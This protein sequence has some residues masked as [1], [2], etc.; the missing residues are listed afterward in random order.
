MMTKK[1]R[2]FKEP[3]LVLLVS[4]LLLILGNSC[5]QTPDAAA[6]GGGTL[7][8]ISGRIWKLAEIRTAAGTTRLDR[9]KLDSK[10]RGD[11]FTLRIDSDRIS[12][13]ASPNRYTSGYKTG[14]A[15][16]LTILFPAST[17]MAALYDPEGIGEREYFDYL[18]KVKRWNLNQDRLELYT[19]DGAGEEAV[20]IYVN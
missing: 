18:M 15:D 3:A 14:V 2:H 17:Q 5:A 11:D 9:E 20:L 13:K 6:S 4:G 12:G 19:S 10:G 1:N 16:S 8:Q 7:A